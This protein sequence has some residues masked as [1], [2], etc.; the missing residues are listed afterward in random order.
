MWTSW[1]MITQ[2]NSRGFNGMQAYRRPTN[3]LGYFLRRQ[4]FRINTINISVPGH[5]EQQ[6]MRIQ[7][8]NETN[9]IWKQ[10]QMSML[11]FWIRY[12][13]AA[14]FIPRVWMLSQ[15]YIGWPLVHS[16][17]FVHTYDYPTSYMPL[18]GIRYSAYTLAVDNIIITETRAQLSTNEI[19]AIEIRSI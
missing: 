4:L 1:K 6:N 7:L 19:C 18:C 12:D 3:T 17:N 8:L 13:C 2:G 16:W 10:C 14:R 5:C 9:Y 15:V 11:S